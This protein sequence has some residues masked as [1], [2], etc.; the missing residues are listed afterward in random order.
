MLKTYPKTDDK[1]PSMAPKN[2]KILVRFKQIDPLVLVWWCLAISIL[3]ASISRIST[4]LSGFAQFALVV[5]GSGGCAWF[6]LFS[7][8]MFRNKKHLSPKLFIAIAAVVFVESTA[9]MIFPIGSNG[10]SSEAG[11]VVHNAASMIC[12]TALAFVFYE[13]L[14]GFKDI[15]SKAERRFRVL[16]TAGFSVLV[17]ITILWL[18]GAAANSFAALW[19][20]ALLTTCGLIAL[21]GSLL[22]IQYRLKNPLIA[23]N[24]NQKPQQIK[25]DIEKSDMIAQ[26]I[27]EAI[28][29]DKLLTTPNLKV[30][31]FADSIGEQ[32]YKVTR[33]ITNTLKY[34]NFNHLLNS[35]RIERAK[36]VFS[37]INNSHLTIATVAYDCGFNSIGPFNRAFRQYTGIT[38]REYRQKQVA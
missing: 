20:P 31:D 29:D 7:C 16:Y 17:G 28:N 32:E 4:G 6:W 34:K 37:D 27:I 38:P 11:R 1:L 9:A 8:Y 5:L 36:R 2:N 19:K 24:P 26:L 13:A 18:S 22:A 15:K 10:T 12:M 25:T 35:H 21:I 30:S 33:S 23:K 14:N 3:C